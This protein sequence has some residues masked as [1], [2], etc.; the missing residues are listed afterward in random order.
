MLTQEDLDKLPLDKTLD[1]IYGIT[2]TDGIYERI[3]SIRKFTRGLR[4]KRWPACE[5]LLATDYRRGVAYMMDLNKPFR[6]PAL[7]HSIFEALRNTA[8]DISDVFEYALDYTTTAVGGR[9]K[10]LEDLILTELAQIDQYCIVWYV[11][12]VIKGPWPAAEKLLDGLNKRSYEQALA[13]F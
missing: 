1:E 13:A 5:A 2:E 3:T 4:G 11:K 6:L 10:E 8:E 12:R 9:W 7:E